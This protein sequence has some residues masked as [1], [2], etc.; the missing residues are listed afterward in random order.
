MNNGDRPTSESSQGLRARTLTASFTA[1]DLDRSVHFY[2]EGLGFEVQERHEDGGQVVFV[3]LEAGEARLG[4]GRDDFAKGRNRVKGVGMR[5][6]ITTDQDLHALAERV[7]AAGYELANGPEPLPWG[8]L[9]F[10]VVDPDGF[11]LTVTNGA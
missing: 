10:A 7:T 1:D 8:P 5:I 2:T 9:A 4:I 3:A 11:A 6:W